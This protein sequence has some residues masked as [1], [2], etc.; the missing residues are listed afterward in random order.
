MTPKLA[1]NEEVRVFVS[2]GHRWRKSPPGGYKGRVTRVGRKLCDIGFHDHT[3]ETFVM[4]TGQMQYAGPYYF[5]TLA[6][7]AERD[8]RLSALDVLVTYGVIVSP[9]TSLT[10][11][12][13]EAMAESARA[14]V[15]IKES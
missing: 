15:T 14:T 8:R 1:V 7:T 13:I 12:Q 4:A 9:G 3:S 10:A 11:D 5:L 6:Q 2:E